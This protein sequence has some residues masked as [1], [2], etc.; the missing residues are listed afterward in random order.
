MTDTAFS[1]S[2]QKE[3]DPEQYMELKD[4]DEG[5]VH[6]VAR[7][8][9]I[10][11]ICKVGGGTLVRASR[12]EGYNKKAHFRFAGENGEGHHPACDFYGD[13]LSAEVSQHL[14]RFTTDRTKYSKVIRKLVCAGLQEGIIT[15]ENMRQMREWFF[16]KRKESSF[17]I[18]LD[19][20]DLGWLEYIAGLRFSHLAWTD[21]DILPFS[22]I[23]ATVPGFLW[24]RAIDREAVRVHQATLQKLRELSVCK[25]DISSIL[26]HL[27]KNR[28]RMILDPELLESEIRKTLKLTAFIRENYVEFKSKT[29]NEKSYAED[30][31]LAFAALLLFVSGWDIDT[32]IGKFSMIARVREVDDMLAGNFIGLNPYFRYDVASAVKRL[33]DAWPIE[34]K[35]IELRDVEQSM[36]DMYEK[37]SR[38]LRFPVPPLAPLP[39]DIYITRHQKW[40]QKQAEI[41]A[42]IN[43][44]EPNPSVDF[45]DF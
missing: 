24:P 13:R 18:L 37:Y 1:K 44:S 42:M 7:E 3:V 39:P 15:Q 12:S 10:C 4:L 22:P 5:S 21:S 8:D 11:P 35:K 40:E 45:D 36:R 27:T 41:E 17:E 29:V 32:A 2:L 34:Y 25:R 38:S 20:E 9:V 30:K 31:F 28:V 43:P 16:N 26:E 19:E 6:A 14:I 33:Q 23:Q